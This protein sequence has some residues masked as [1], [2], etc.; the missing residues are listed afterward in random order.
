M[1]R[2]KGSGELTPKKQRFAQSIANQYTDTRTFSASKAVRD[3]GYD[4]STSAGSDRVMGSQLMRD[5]TVQAEV[6][7]LLARVGLTR[8]KWANRLAQAIDAKEVKLAQLEGKFTDRVE[9][10]DWS[11]SLKALDMAGKAIG[12][13]KT[14]DD[15]NQQNLI[16]LHAP[17]IN[18]DEEH[19]SDCDCAKCI[20]KLTK[21]LPSG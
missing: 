20:S 2:K 6:E 16:I 11:N 21:E 14:S 5:E 10:E 9:V 17:P 1:P 15:G 19:A 4:V 18:L 3:A 12:L 13:I 8:E 7:R